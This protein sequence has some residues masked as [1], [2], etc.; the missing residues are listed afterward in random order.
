MVP[1]LPFQVGDNVGIINVA[2]HHAHLNGEID[3][4]KEHGEPDYPGVV[5]LHVGHHGKDPTRNVGEQDEFQGE[6]DNHEKKIGAHPPL[7]IVGK[8]AHNLVDG[9]GRR[10]VYSC[11]I[12]KLKKNMVATGLFWLFG[13]RKILIL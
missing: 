3:Q 12:L 5:G 7:P 4:E 9:F 8:L 10:H 13:K 6:M 11:A 1:D 2:R